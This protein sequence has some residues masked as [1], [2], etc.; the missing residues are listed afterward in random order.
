ML[1]ARAQE[2][3]VPPAGRSGCGLQCMSVWAAR[4]ARRGVQ[5]GS[6]APRSGQKVGSEAAHMA[7]PHPTRD[8]S[9]LEAAAHLER[10]A[11]EKVSSRT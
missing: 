10:G 1:A 3:K 5:E 2:P 11:V 7:K 6:A 4:E 9:R 8:L